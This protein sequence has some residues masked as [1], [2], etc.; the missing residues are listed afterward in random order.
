MQSEQ[1]SFIDVRISLE[2]RWVTIITK[3]NHLVIQMK[4]TFLCTVFIRFISLFFRWILVVW[5]RCV[6]FDGLFVLNLEETV[7]RKYG[8]GISLS[9][10][11]AKRN[12]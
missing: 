2:N 9:E 12:R 8:G 1:N 4:K 11:P 5:E 7:W 10:Y 6:S 3:C